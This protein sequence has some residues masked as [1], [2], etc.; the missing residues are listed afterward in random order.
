MRTFLAALSLLLMAQ[1]CEPPPPPPPD[2]P[3]DG[4]NYCHGREYTILDQI[5][6]DLGGAWDTI[7]G[8]IES[9]D[10][11]ATVQVFFADGYCS[12]VALSP[13]TVLTAGHC[14]AFASQHS[15][16]LYGQATRYESTEHL[17][18]PDYLRY[19]ADPTLLEARKADL[20]LVFTADAIPGPYINVFDHIY[21]SVLT[22]N[23]WGMIAQ[24]HGKAE[25]G[26]PSGQ[27]REAE[28][29]ITQETD[30]YIISRLTDAG[31]ICFGDS[32]GPLYADV[33]TITG[34]QLY[35]AGITTT[36][37]S[38]DCLVGGTH[39]KIGFPD[40]ASWIATNMRP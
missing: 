3:R 5:M 37:M 33:N 36:T 31:K 38:S 32:G 18:H 30:K 2:V 40:F 7:I 13:H 14:G 10:R 35:L 22:D 28:Y 12:G 17:T 8:G 25:D 27:L 34:H 26:L 16:R 4:T 11:R 9:A 24:G 1:S 21:T 29:L 19:Q 6:D 23:C 39:V 15:I 20:Q